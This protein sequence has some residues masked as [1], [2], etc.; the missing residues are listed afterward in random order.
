MDGD[1][2]GRFALQRVLVAG[3]AL[4]AGGC[5]QTT[6]QAISEPVVTAPIVLNSA[7]GARRGADGAGARRRRPRLRARW[8][9]RPA[10]V[11]APCRRSPVAPASASRRSRWPPR[12]ARAA[13]DGRAGR[14]DRRRVP[15]HQ[16]AADAAGRDAAAGG[17]AGADHRRARSAPRRAGTAARQRRRQRRR[18]R[19]PGRHPR[20][21]PRSSRSRPAR[22]RARC[23][24]NPDCA[25]AD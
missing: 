12:G 11:A 24:N 19:R 10:P 2:S 6:T 22:T 25:T 15:E 13:A 18:S 5:A 23:Q 21:R 16:P 1:A 4:G 9:R 7:P 14:R 3:L 8:P 17:G 20:R